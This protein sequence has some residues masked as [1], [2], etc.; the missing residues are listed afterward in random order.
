VIRTTGLSALLLLGLVGAS[1][2]DPPA[3][4]R[5]PAAVQLLAITDSDPLE[6]ARVAR[7]V[8]DDAVLALLDR[9]QPGDACLAAVR[10]SPWL[11]EPERALVLLAP[12]IESRDSDLAPAAARAAFQIARAIDVSTLDRREIL[13]AELLPAHAALRAASDR[14]WVRP[15][16]RLLA[17]AAVAQLEAA[18]VVA[19]SSK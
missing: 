18:G 5:P 1:H 13:P 3:P 6:L 16:L 8:G 11:R 15:D 14:A 2:A 10:A 12:M 7:L 19:A 17:A 4:A 9:A